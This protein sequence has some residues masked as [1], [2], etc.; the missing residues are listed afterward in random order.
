[1]WSAWA[2]FAG[3]DGRLLPPFPEKHMIGGEGLSRLQAPESC[4]GF[5]RMG[6]RVNSETTVRTDTQNR[7]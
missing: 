5:N 4:R 7:A 3:V 2:T 6:F 1:M